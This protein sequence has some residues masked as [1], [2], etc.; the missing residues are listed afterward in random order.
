M[1]FQGRGWGAG[2]YCC[3]WRCCQGVGSSTGTLA[4]CILSFCSSSFLCFS[5]FFPFLFW[6]FTGTLAGCIFSLFAVHF[7]FFLFFLFFFGSS[8]GTLAGCFSLL[9]FFFFFFCVTFS[10]F[11]F[12]VQFQDSSRLYHVNKQD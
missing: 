9:F 1:L 2:S 10:L 11:L 5:L 3:W 7:L 6:A 8:T 12:W 4:G